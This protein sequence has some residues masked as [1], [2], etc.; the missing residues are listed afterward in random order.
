MC[1]AT[2]PP[3]PTTRPTMAELAKWTFKNGAAALWTAARSIYRQSIPAMM[4]FVALVTAYT[5]GTLGWS[6]WSMIIV[7]L[8]GAFAVSAAED[9]A[10]AAAKTEWAERFLRMIETDH[11]LSVTITHRAED[12]ANALR[13]REEKKRDTDHG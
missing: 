7:Y 9:R 5:F 13:E 4:L 6:M 2:S 1:A 3:S 11:D 12:I 8:I 10:E